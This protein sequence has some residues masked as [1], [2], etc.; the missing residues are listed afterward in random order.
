M[1]DYEDIEQY[2]NREISLRSEN[3][4]LKKE[5]ICLKEQVETLIN[6]KDTLI[7]EIEKNSE[8]KKATIQLKEK[9]KKLQAE[10]IDYKKRSYELMEKQK[11]WLSLFSTNVADITAE[12]KMLKKQLVAKEKEL[13]IVTERYTKMMN[14]KIMKWT[15]KYWNLLKKIN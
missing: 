4:E 12:N 2:I 11:N 6:K 8:D 1:T 15:G 5:I 3:S 13:Q 14:T 10:L 7:A 9:V